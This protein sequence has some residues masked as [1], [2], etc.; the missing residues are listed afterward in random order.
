MRYINTFP[1]HTSVVIAIDLFVYKLH[2]VHC[3]GKH[4]W[5]ERYN[6]TYT[7]TI[8]KYFQWMVYP[9]H[10]GNCYEYFEIGMW[11]T[12]RNRFF[13]KRSLPN[14]TLLHRYYIFRITGKYFPGTTWILHEYVKDVHPR[15]CVANRKMINSWPTGDSL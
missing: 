1:E 4:S 7:K 15:F 6:V 9:L 8:F 14:I 2:W 3:I 10:T 12:I 13:V 5:N 11:P